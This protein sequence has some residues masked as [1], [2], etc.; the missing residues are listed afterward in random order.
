MVRCA[1]RFIIALMALLVV[2]ALA[3]SVASAAMTLPEFKNAE[4][5]TS[6]AG[7]STVSVEGGASRACTGTSGTQN[8]KT[9]S[10]NLG[11]Y[12]LTFTG[13]TEGGESC[14]SLGGTAGRIVVSG[15]WH[16]VLEEKN[17]IHLWLFLFLLPATDVHVECPKAPIKL[18]LLLG[19]LLGLLEPGAGT[20]T[21]EYKLIITTSN[22]AQAESSYENNEGKLLTTQ[23]LLMS[24][25]NGKEKK[26]GLSTTGATLKFPVTNEIKN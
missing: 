16:L 25:E 15:E 14:L 26:A 23:I 20:A 22:G 19:V 9:G 3:A 2:G 13:C 8:F 12:T 10:K 24:Q 17:G 11:T 5:S 4:N 21:K 18:W 1:R 6:A 7:T